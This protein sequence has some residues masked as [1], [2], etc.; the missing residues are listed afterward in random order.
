MDPQQLVVL[1]IVQGLSEF[2]PV[3]SSAHLI[4]VP[5]L[6]KWPDQGL[7]FDIAVHVGSLLAVLGYFRVEVMSMLKAWLQSLLG[8]EPSANSRLAWWVI[9]GTLPAVAVGYLSKDIIETQLR[10][11][12]V[13][14]IA[15]IVFGLLLWVADR[16]RKHRKTEYQLTLGNVLM[17]GFFQALAL[18]PGTSRSGITITA[19]LLLGMTRS[20]AARFSFLL[21]MPLIFASGVLQTLDL[22]HEPVAIDWFALLLAVLLSAVSAGLCIHFFLRLID[23]VGMLP[24]VVYRLLLG[25]LLVVLLI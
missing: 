25:G 17:I 5:L 23:K 22:L 9:L 3:S 4:L 10:S 7:A 12:W 19:G 20:A 14:A 21:S 16:A 1:A 11:P 15:T 24:F 18:I 8:D 2:L 13:I 6:L